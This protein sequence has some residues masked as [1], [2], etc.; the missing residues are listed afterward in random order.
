[1]K[2][3]NFYIICDNIRS[4]ENIGSI[5]RTADALVVD[6]IFLCGI[7]GRPPHSKISKTAL[8]AENN[9]AWEH[10]GQVWRVIDKLKKQGVNIIALEQTKHSLDY[11]KFKPKFP[12]ALVLGNEIKGICQSVLKKADEIVHL[13]ML[14]SKESLNISVAFGI[15][16]YHLRK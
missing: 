6:K 1:M 8:G 3:H 10:Y 4:L 2:K 13:P 12:L 11:R 14:G 16:G 9:V 7:C 15:I 5:F